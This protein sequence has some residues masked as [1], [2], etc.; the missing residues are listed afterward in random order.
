MLRVQLKRY[1]RPDSYA[2]WKFERF[3]KL[4]EQR[5]KQEFVNDLK[6]F[7]ISSL[8]SK[9]WICNL[10]LFEFDMLDEYVKKKQKQ[11]KQEYLKEIIDEYDNATAGCNDIS[12]F[13][14]WLMEEKKKQ[15]G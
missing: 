15:G 2:L 12:V 13:E 1:I 5:A 6:Q 11:A 10:N 4:L 8:D 9:N 3:E 14:E 7:K